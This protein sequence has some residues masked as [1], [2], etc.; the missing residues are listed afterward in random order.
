MF[1]VCYATYS[2]N[3]FQ[4]FPTLSQTH[5]RSC[6]TKFNNTTIRHNRQ[7]S[8]LVQNTRAFP[9]RPASRAI[10]L[11]HFSSDEKLPP[12]ST[13]AP[14]NPIREYIPL[15]RAAEF[16]CCYPHPH[17]SLPDRRALLLNMVRVSGLSQ[18]IVRPGLARFDLSRDQHAD[19]SNTL[20][21]HNLPH[22][23]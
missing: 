6:S 10:F 22:Y 7:E 9:S 17:R 16:R 12:L 3:S 18:L 14:F 13:N 23:L 5:S 2:N 15:C 19:A 20:S 8:S 21:Q 11:S 1:S 4:G